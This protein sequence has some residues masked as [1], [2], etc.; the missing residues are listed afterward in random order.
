[1]IEN[2]LERTDAYILAKHQAVAD[3][4]NGWRDD[5]SPYWLAAQVAG[6]DSVLNMGTLF[7]MYVNGDFLKAGIRLLI[8]AF[9]LLWFQIAYSAHRRWLSRRDLPQY[10]S[11]SSDS[12]RKAFLVLTLGAVPYSAAWV[13]MG[14]AE[15][16]FTVALVCAS[17]VAGT[18]CMY[19]A[20]CKPPTPRFKEE[21]KAL[22]DAV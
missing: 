14:M 21:W 22:P 16:W 17:L 12:F 13:I 6:L 7:L 9:A 3:Y 5:I 10:T 15:E 8:G 11:L 4:A 20:A 19:F 1:M 2:I 18:V